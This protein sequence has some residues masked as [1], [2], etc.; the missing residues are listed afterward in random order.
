MMIRNIKYLKNAI[1]MKPKTA[2]QS[3]A[4]GI[5]SENIVEYTN[6]IDKKF[7]YDESYTETFRMNAFR[8]LI[9]T[10]TTILILV[11]V[12][13]ILIAIDVDVAFML[14]AVIFLGII[15]NI[16]DI[17]N[18][19]TTTFTVEKFSIDSRVSFLSQIHNSFSVDKITRVD[20]LENPID[21]IFR[22]MTVSFY[23]IGS[24]KKIIFKNIKKTE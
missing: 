5:Q 23:S 10:I 13:I 12:T 7:D 4:S 1:S 11:I 22:T 17:I 19:F 16:R 8:T 14:S 2:D 18:T 21:K 3:N 9:G 6:S 15:A 24:S 20:F